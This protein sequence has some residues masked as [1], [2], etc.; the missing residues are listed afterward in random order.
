MAKALLF[1]TAMSARTGPTN[2]ASRFPRLCS[3]FYI[4]AKRVTSSPSTITMRESAPVHL[5]AKKF[6]NVMINGSDLEHPTTT[7]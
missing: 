3:L 2:I 1:T 7:H 5:R 4:F 6:L